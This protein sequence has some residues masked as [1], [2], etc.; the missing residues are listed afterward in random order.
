MPT[1]PYCRRSHYTTSS[2]K[3]AFTTLDGLWEACITERSPIG[4]SKHDFTLTIAGGR[5]SCKSECSHYDGSSWDEVDFGKTRSGKS[6]SATQK[7]TKAPSW[8]CGARLC[9]LSRVEGRLDSCGRA[10][11]RAVFT[12]SSPKGDTMDIIQ[13]GRMK[14]SMK[15]KL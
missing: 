6:F 13:E 8:S 11:F 9:G 15:R 5:A 12:V 7:M 2:T 1:C 4:C 14:R 10:T 3:D